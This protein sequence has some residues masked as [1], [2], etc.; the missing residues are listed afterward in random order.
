M[1]FRPDLFVRAATSDVVYTINPDLKDSVQI[2]EAYS[3]IG[4]VIGKALFERIVIDMHFD[5]CLLGYLVGLPVELEDLQTLDTP[6]MSVV[7]ERC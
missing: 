5:D 4:K 7:F 2:L 6:V 1:N 3:F